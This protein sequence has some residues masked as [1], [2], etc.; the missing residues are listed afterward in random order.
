MYEVDSEQ[1]HGHVAG[2]EKLTEL[3]SQ[4]LDLSDSKDSPLPH[5]ICQTFSHWSETCAMKL[6]NEL[7]EEGLYPEERENAPKWFTC[8]E[9]MLRFDTMDLLQCHYEDMHSETA[10][11]KFE[12]I[13]HLTPGAKATSMMTTLYRCYVVKA[14]KSNE[15]HYEASIKPARTRLKWKNIT[16]HLFQHELSAVSADRITL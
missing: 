13:E 11:Q 6:H 8:P 16:E 5:V 4:A 12:S 10:A 9:C 7:V 3:I 2:V 1:A 15:E 14:N